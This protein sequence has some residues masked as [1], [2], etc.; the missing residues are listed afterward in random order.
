MVKETKKERIETMDNDATVRF[1]W[2]TGDVNYLDYG[3]KW[4][5]NT[6]VEV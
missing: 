2:L 5:Y 1:T 3:G 4:F 6:K